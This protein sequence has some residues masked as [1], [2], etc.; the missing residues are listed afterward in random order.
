VS[1]S[2][3]ALVEIARAFGVAGSVNPDQA[4]ADAQAAFR[5]EGESLDLRPRA[6]RTGAGIFAAVS[7][8]LT[9]P[10]KVTFAGRPLSEM[11]RELERA[12]TAFAGY[13]SY[14]GIAIHDYRAFRQLAEASSQAPV[15]CQKH[16]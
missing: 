14:A 3:D 15:A 8:T 13:R 11:T 4:A 10:P 6:I 16:P 7:A 9:T 1:G 12:E 2:D 5:R